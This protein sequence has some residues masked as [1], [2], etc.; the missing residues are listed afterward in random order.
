M[1]CCPLQVDCSIDKIIRQCFSR[2]LD[3][4]LKMFCLS[5]KRPRN[6][7]KFTP[8]HVRNA[9]GSLHLPNMRDVR[10]NWN[11]VRLVVQ[12]SGEGFQNH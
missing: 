7:D 3:S 4:S 1:S 5:S 10:D 8:S 2:K 12:C 11:Q 6:E 9:E